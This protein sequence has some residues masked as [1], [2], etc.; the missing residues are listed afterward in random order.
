MVNNIIMDEATTLAR[1]DDIKKYDTFRKLL[2]NEISRLYDSIYG[3]VY[4][5]DGFEL[6]E[7]VTEEEANKV[8][9]EM[10]YLHKIDNEY[11]DKIIGIIKSF[12]SNYN[13]EGM[14]MVDDYDFK[15]WC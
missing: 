5:D 4:G 9:A 14:R 2:N 6:R 1:M 12:R 3:D 7:G 13:Y 8:E 10:E 11:K 15:V